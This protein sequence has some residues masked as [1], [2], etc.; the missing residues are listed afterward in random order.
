MAPRDSL[1][2][3]RT[4]SPFRAAA[5][6]KAPPK[7]LGV[8]PGDWFRAL[9]LWFRFTLK[10]IHEMGQFLPGIPLSFLLPPQC[11]PATWH[12]DQ[13]VEESIKE[14]S[15]RPG[16]GG[17]VEAL[18]SLVPVPPIS[19]H[20]QKHGKDVIGLLAVVPGQIASDL[21]KKPMLPS[22]TKCWSPWEVPRWLACMV[23]EPAS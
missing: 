4:I 8:H 1:R 21:G 10:P 13:R 3:N 2:A 6:Q 15:F 20:P 17:A 5:I 9:A 16:I 12:L 19:I 22:M 11:L 7:P 14:F 23:L 18:A